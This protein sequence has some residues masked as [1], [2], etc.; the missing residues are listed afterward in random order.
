MEKARKSRISAG[1]SC[2]VGILLLRKNH[3]SFLLYKFNC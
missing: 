3:D 1:S 2:G